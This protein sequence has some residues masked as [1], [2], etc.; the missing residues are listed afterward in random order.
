[1]LPRFL[2]DTVEQQAPRPVAEQA[3]SL[4][5]TSAGVIEIQHG[6]MP[7]RIEGAP[8]ETMLRQILDRILR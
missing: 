1:M 7:I 4:T 3:R 6:K 5:R 8:D 2:D